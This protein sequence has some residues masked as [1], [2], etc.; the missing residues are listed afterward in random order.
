[1][2]IDMVNS[3]LTITTSDSRAEIGRLQSTVSLDRQVFRVNEASTGAPDVLR[4][5]PRA[6]D[7]LRP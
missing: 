5:N 6:I 4:A 1:V 2:N 7:V 3:I